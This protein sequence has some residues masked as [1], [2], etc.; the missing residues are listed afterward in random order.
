MSSIDPNVNFDAA[1]AEAARRQAAAR[2]PDEPRDDLGEPTEAA[3][4][5]TRAPLSQQIERETEQPR[6]PETQQ[7][8]S[9]NDPLV[10][11]GSSPTFE[12]E[13]PVEIIEEVPEEPSPEPEP[14]PLA[15]KFRS[16]EEL[17]RAY[18]ELEQFEGR[19]SATENELRQQIAELQQRMSQPY[20][21][22]QPALQPVMTEEQIDAGV[23]RG[24]A[25]FLASLY[26]SSHPSY[27]DALD[28][29]YD[30]NPRL[31][32]DWQAR[33]AAFEAASELEARVA[34]QLAAVAAPV[35]RNESQTRWNGA[36]RELATAN[37]EMNL[38]AEVMMKDLE[39]NPHLSL[40]MKEQ[41]P[42]AEK[43]VLE[44]LLIRAR[45]ANRDRVAEAAR[46]RDEQVGRE[47]RDAHV[48][49]ASAG[50]VRTGGQ[51]EQVAEAVRDLKASILGHQ[52]GHN[53]HEA[54]AKARGG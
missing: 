15:G 50:A 4:Q 6:D 49:S 29:M 42:G 12:E 25:E 45:D 21:A 8:R 30:V 27:D 41:L 1:L 16:P 11:F 51:G 39:A 7:F 2:E 54:I 34:P 46:Q 40:P 37:P 33:V 18:L 53:V 38:L 26:E 14:E 23:A 9:P 22:P 3:G 32:G 47:K 13:E 5:G 24:G 10:R 43:I 28:R 36:W 48:V 20:G 44:N 19:R 52:T 35:S 31:A 17:E